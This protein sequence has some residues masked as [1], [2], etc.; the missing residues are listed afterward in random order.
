[1]HTWLPEFWPQGFSLPEEVRSCFGSVDEGLEE[2]DFDPQVRDMSLQPG[3]LLYFRAAAKGPGSEQGVTFR[4]SCFSR[5]TANAEYWIVADATKRLQELNVRQKG[6]VSKTEYRDT[7]Y[8][9]VQPD[10]D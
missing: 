9:P 7:D 4:V 1:M 2:S 5:K 3:Q 6:L 10:R 8:G